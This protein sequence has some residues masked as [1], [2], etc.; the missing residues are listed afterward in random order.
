MNSHHDLTPPANPPVIWITGASQGIGEAV[1]IAMARAGMVVAA[2][3]RNVERLAALANQSTDL[4]GSIAPYPLDVTDQAA[5][6]MTVDKIIAQHGGIDQAI[7]NAGTYIPS[8]ATGFTSDAVRQQVEL[9]LM[10]V[11]HCLEPLIT[12][13]TGRGKGTIAMNASLAGY[14]GLPRAAGYGA[15]KAALINMA[16]S[17]N[18]ELSD[19]GIDIKVINPGF[20]KTPLTSK[21]RFP[22]PFLMEVD[23][24]AE[25][26]VKG[27]KGRQFEIRFPRIFAAILG[28]LR[29]LP[30]PLYFW[31]I[32]KAG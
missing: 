22:M 19:V 23:K 8:P 21:N 31:L 24:A 12:Y 28:L 1:A 27:M 5:V 26:I 30:Y 17:L 16:E 9:N 10:G 7:L 14:R 18:T 2:S 15:S 29:S 13:M 6:K 4:T 32:R 20:V 25:L 3:A 11:C